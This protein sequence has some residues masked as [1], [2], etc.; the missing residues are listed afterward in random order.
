MKVCIFDIKRF[1]VHDGPGIRSTVFFK[2]CPLECRWCHNPEGIRTGIEYFREKIAFD[3]VE[4][5]RETE[6]GRWIGVEELM[7]ELERDRI[8]M[9]ESGGGISIS[10]GEPFHQ[11]EALFR[12]LELAGERKLHTTLDTSGYTRPANIERAS[13]LADLI[14]YDLKTMDKDKHLKYTGV[15]NDGILKNLELAL[16][17]SAA[18]IIRIP[19]VSGFNDREDETGSMLDFLGGLPGIQGV[20]ILPYHP[21]GTHKYRRFNR[22]DRQNGFGVPARERIEAVRKRFSDAGFR[23]KIGG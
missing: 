11:P 12:L 1:A 20:D 10:G 5:L 8:Y 9:E 22:E 17:G 4:I 7:N 15:S 3:G 16:K 13:S 18:V 14:L 2:G 6:V 19:L 23:V 21:Y